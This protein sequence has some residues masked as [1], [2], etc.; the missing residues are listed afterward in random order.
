[1]RRE[2]YFAAHEATRLRTS[3]IGTPLP[4]SMSRTASSQRAQQAL[5]F[6]GSQLRFAL[7]IEPEGRP[8]AARKLGD[9]ILN[10]NQ[11]AHGGGKLT[12]RSHFGKRQFPNGA[13]RSRRF[14]A[15]NEGGLNIF[16]T[17]H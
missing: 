14:N 11:R 17:S 8:F 3:F 2:V 1:L 16:N 15:P 5:F 10:F 9:S 6:Q 7:G 13:R 12:R 4:A